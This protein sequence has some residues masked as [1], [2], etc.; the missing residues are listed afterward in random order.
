[1]LKLSIQD[2]E[3]R[4]T[5]VPLADGELSIGRDEANSICLSD[6]NVS[7][8]H[9]R[10]TTRNG[11]VFVENIQATYGTRFNNLLLRERAEV[12]EG[13]VLQ[14]G[15]YVLELVTDENKKRDNALVDDNA[16]PASASSPLKARPDNATAVVNLADLAAALK[17]E[18]AGNAVAIPEAAQPRLVVESE[19]MRGLE[20]RIT[21]TP[22]VVGRV[23]EN[24]DLVIDHRSISKEH[25]R[26]TRQADGSW[27]IL[28][29]GSA[30]GLKVN[31]EPY[32]KSD[33]VSGDRIELGH[34][35]MRFLAAGAR[36]PALSAA[37]GASAKAKAPIGLILAAVG[38]VVAIGGGALVF[39]LTR[40]DKTPSAATASG[41]AAVA[42]TPQEAAPAAKPEAEKGPTPEEALRQAD[43]LQQGGMLDD[44]L[45]VLKAAQA[46]HAGNAPLGAAARQV[47][48]EIGYKKALADAD[49]NFAT[50]PQ[51]SVATATEIR[52]K[53]KDGSSL[54]DA[55][56]AIIAKGKAG[57]AEPQ[58]PQHKPKAPEPAPRAVPK[59][60]P[61]VALH[62]KP[63][64]EAAP[65]KP[66][67]KP[68]PKP[69]PVAEAKKSGADLYKEGRDAMLAGH[70]DDAVSLFKQAVKAGNGKG[71]GQL[72]RIFFQKGDKGQ[73]AQAAKAYLDRYPD[74]GDAQPIQSLL[75]KCSN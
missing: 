43:K 61:K 2:N 33:I 32:S 66:E 53:L 55:A 65:P 63:K 8:Q 21:R 17:P 54:I 23:R 20:L 3:G 59:P 52:G 13:D 70:S 31:G 25:A 9:A 67:P 58:P 62:E 73:C 51:A 42:P 7:R 5:Y 16:T 27:Q 1:M 11:H 46:E 30:N 19:N 10:L 69:A 14:V 39:L 44:A 18:A 75:E 48:L 74:A 4:A 12:I 26:L 71:Y 72:A 22:I 41:Q 60:E 38:A 29:L 36:A 40:G 50:N 15:D 37:D 47:E 68:E 45:A 56:D 64:P 35:A 24:A 57:T 6:R 49:A 28:D 34:V